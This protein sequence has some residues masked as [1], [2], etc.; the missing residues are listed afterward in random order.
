MPSKAEIEFA[1][2]VTEAM[3]RAKEDKR[4]AVSLRGKMIDLP[5]LLQA[6]RTLHLAR[7]AGLIQEEPDGENNHEA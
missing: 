5:V 6:E 4:G 1:L 3:R 2:D 7:A